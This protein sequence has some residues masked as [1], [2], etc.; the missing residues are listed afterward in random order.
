MVG[1]GSSY[2]YVPVDND[3]VLCKLTSNYPC[4]IS[5]T[6]LSNF[7]HM[8]VQPGVAPV[9]TVGVS[10]GTSIGATVYNT[11]LTATVT[12]AGFAPAYQW[13]V[14]GTAVAGATSVSYTA[15]VLKNNDIV[16]CFVT[17]NSACGAQNATGTATIASA[18]VGVK[19]VVGTGSDIRLVPNPNKG[20]FTI[21]GNT[22]VASDEMLTLEITDMIGQVVYN[23]KVSVHNGEINQHVVLDRTLANG[24]YLLN[25]RSGSDSKVFHMV[26]EQ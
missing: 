13:L 22:G 6:V 19:P 9:V 24:M 3:I 15:P 26:V 20:N 2:S 10:Y 16:A 7:E 8:T 12:N 17:T 1:T 23:G 18:T 11:T 4:L 14:N 21:S 25:L 5:A